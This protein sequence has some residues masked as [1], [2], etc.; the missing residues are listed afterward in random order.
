[1]NLYSFGAADKEGACRAVWD[2]KHSNFVTHIWQEGKAMPI[3]SCR[4][5]TQE[6][7]EASAR[8][9]REA[10]EQQALFETPEFQDKL[11]TALEGTLATRLRSVHGMDPF[12]RKRTK[13]AA[14]LEVEFLVGAMS[15]INVVFPGRDSELSSKVPVYWA[16]CMMSGRSVLAATKKS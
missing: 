10:L 5:A 1:M 14:E 8:R 11:K 3:A 4:E 16:M 6:A 12:S 7:C 9:V 2:P 15:A 13:R